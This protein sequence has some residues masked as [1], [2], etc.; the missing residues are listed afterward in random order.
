[1]NPRSVLWALGAL[2]LSSAFV[3]LGCWQWN[4]G[5]FKETQR[6]SFER[7]LVA[8]PAPLAD[9]V[10]AEHAALPLRVS[11]AGRFEADATLLLDN[12]T[13]DGHAGVPVLTLFRPDGARRGVLVDRGFVALPPDRRVPAIAAPAASAVVTGL[14]ATPPATGVR[15]GEAHA[16]R[17]SLSL[18]PWLD[19]GIVAK[20]FHAELSDAVVL[21]DDAAPDGFARRWEPLRNTMPPERHRAYAA[22]WFALAAAVWITYGVLMWRRRR[23]K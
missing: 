19:I 5:A 12:Q 10:D 2:A 22:Q 15:L 20:D 3:A 11:G 13:L 16:V 18:V 6:A 9:A 21:L 7:A 17:G 23:P 4:R 1:M 8:A 14:L